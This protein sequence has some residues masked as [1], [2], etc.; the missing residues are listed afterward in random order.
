MSFDPR[1][2]RARPFPLPLPGEVWMWSPSYANHVATCLIVSV[3]DSK[4]LTV[5]NA[6]KLKTFRDPITFACVC[7]RLA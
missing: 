5:T 3:K 7:W 6:G 2:E 4:V 1:G